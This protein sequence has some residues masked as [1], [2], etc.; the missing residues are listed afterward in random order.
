MT[1]GDEE[2][3]DDELEDESPSVSDAS[4]WPGALPKQAAF[5]TALVF[6][7]GQHGKAARAAGV[8]RATHYRWMDVSEDYRILY[9]R[10]M[11]QV[12]V[13]LEDEAL[14]RAKDGIPKGIYFKGEKVA[15]ERLYSDGLMMFLLRG[16]APDKYRER[17]EHTGKDG[18]PIESKIEVVFVRPKE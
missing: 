2:L 6:H 18:G 16:A 15:T 4:A 9:K 17:T 11:E 1:A 3:L 5:L 8:A 14:R 13:V 12:T 10:A 7:G